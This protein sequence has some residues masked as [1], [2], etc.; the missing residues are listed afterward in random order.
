MPKFNYVAVGPDGAQ[1]TGVEEA[2]T[3]A[4]LKGLL[5]GRNLAIQEAQEKK[6]IMQF[7][8][9]RKK[10]PRKDLMHFSRQMAVFLRAGI[11]VIDALNIIGEELPKKS[12]LGDCITDMVQSLAAGTT[13]TGA[14]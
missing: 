11:P 2:D 10:V 7:E 6:S 1:V 3:F 13:F 14:A 4:T 12:V 8:L 9:T 5:Q